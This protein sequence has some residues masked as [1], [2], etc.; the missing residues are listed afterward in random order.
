MD[1][2]KADAFGDRMVETLNAGSLALMVSIGHRTGLLDVMAGLSPSTSQEIED[3]SE[4]NERYVREWLGAMAAAKIVEYQPDGATYALPEEHAAFLTRDASPNNVASFLQW[5]ALM[6]G[7][8][9]SII[10]CFK[11]GGGVPAV[12]GSNDGG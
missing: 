5:V 7:V 10:D 3:A 4:L 6:G 12:S 1:Q 9:D 8:E 11:N 2:V